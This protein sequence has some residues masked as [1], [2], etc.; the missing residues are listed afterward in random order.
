[1]D[2]FSTL[3]MASA[4]IEPAFTDYEPAEVTVPPTRYRSRQSRRAAGCEE[5]LSDVLQCSRQESNLHVFRHR[6]LRPACLPFHHESVDDS[7]A[8]SSSSR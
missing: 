3:H 1:M 7:M 4:G 8:Y 2:R 5:P 6:V